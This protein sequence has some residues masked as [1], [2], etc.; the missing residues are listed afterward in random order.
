MAKIETV[1]EDGLVEQMVSGI[2]QTSTP[3]PEQSSRVW[4]YEVLSEVAGEDDSR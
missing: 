1:V 3:S 2:R 4:V